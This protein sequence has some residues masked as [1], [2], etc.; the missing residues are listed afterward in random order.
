MPGKLLNHFL[1][2]TSTTSPPRRP[3]AIARWS[4]IRREDS[5]IRTARSAATR[6]RLPSVRTAR[7]PWAG[8]YRRWIPTLM[9]PAEQL[10]LGGP[11]PELRRGHLRPH[12]DDGWRPAHHAIRDQVR[13][14]RLFVGIARAAAAHRVGAFLGVKSSSAD[15][16]PRIRSV[17]MPD[18][19]MKTYCRASRSGSMS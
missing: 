14:L 3:T 4:A 11:Q 10:Q 15:V 18:S 13:V 19:S 7:S 12:H 16:G 6:I 9:Q 5:T 2:S 17:V 8:P 1:V